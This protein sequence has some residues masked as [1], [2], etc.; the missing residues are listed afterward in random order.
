MRRP[1]PV[2]A[3]FLPFLPCPSPSAEMGR[4]VIRPAGAM[5][6]TFRSLPGFPSNAS[7]PGRPEIRPCG[8]PWPLKWP[9]RC[10]GKNKTAFTPHLDTGDFVIIVKKKNPPGGPGGKTPPPL[11]KRGGFF[12]F[13][14]FPPK[15]SGKQGPIR[16]STAATPAQARR[17]KTETFAP[18]QARLHRADRREGGSRACC[19]HNALA[20]AVVPQT[21]SLQGN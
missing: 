18:L 15:K 13:F 3:E 11:Q 4:Y 5:N 14:I 1:E 21:S 19:P 20:P 10:C 2:L 17:M 12:F 8:P 7:G 9:G 16:R 6:K